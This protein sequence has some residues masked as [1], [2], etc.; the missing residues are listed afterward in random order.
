MSEGIEIKV[1]NKFLAEKRDL[2]VYHHAAR[3]ANLI[4]IDSRITFPLRTVEEEDYVHISVVRGPGSLKQECVVDLPFWLDFDFSSVEEGVIRRTGNRTLLTIPPGPPGW[5]VK[6]TR[7]PGAADIP[8][9]DYIT[10]GNS[11]QVTGG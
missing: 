4:G 11:D 8:A 2:S 9:V 7:S 6:V 10:I 5:Q 1:L 3:S